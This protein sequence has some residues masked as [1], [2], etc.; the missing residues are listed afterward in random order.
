MSVL[1]RVSV[2]LATVVMSTT[3]LAGTGPRRGQAARANGELLLSLPAPVRRT[4]QIEMAN[5]LLDDVTRTNSD[6]GDVIYDVD[7]TRAGKSRNLTVALDGRL[8]DMQVYLLELPLTVR[9]ALK[10]LSA[11]GE[12][13]D[14]TKNFGL[15]D[16]ATYDADIS[17][18]G[19]TRVYTVDEA[20]ALVQ[21][22]VFLS[23]TPPAV[24]K[25]IQG[26]VGSGKLDD[27]TKLMDDEDVSYEVSFI[28]DDRK[29]S[30][31]V[32]AAG[33]VLERQVFPEEIPDPVK[34]AITG[35]GGRG[36]IGKTN[37]S[38]DEGK[39][40]YEAEVRVGPNT[41]RVTFTSDGQLDSEE[42]DMALATVPGPV[43]LALRLVE[44]PLEV[45][46]D[47]TR[48]SEGT[49][50]TYDIELFNGK[51]HRRV[52]FNPDGKIVAR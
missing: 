7:F 21:M 24:Q 18:D 41:S 8:L 31:S 39:D 17:H 20:G 5:G 9:D 36:R 3:V 11:D 29:R 49:N 37:K 42:E 38:T 13:G 25:A 19:V 52:T 43:K 23:E 4:I 12:L 22:Q 16:D 10:K 32:N 33:E 51:S 40:Y 47:I 50:T 34:I 35:L 1:T 48:T 30:F 14:I 44:N 46:T 27:I 6:E 15:N 26:T 28:R 45:V 2:V